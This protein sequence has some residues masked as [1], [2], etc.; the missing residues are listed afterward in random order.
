MAPEDSRRAWRA[1][2]LAGLLLI[3]S[4]ATLAV[5]TPPDDQTYTICLFRRLT[6]HACPTCG[7]TRALALLAKGDWRASIALHPLGLP[8]AAELVLLWSLSPL[9]MLRSHH[10]SAR[11][12]HVLLFANIAVF[13]MVWVLRLL[14]VFP[15]LN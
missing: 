2:L 4:W 7:M 3:G 13:M 14:H 10:L 9:A 5:W 6:H 1:W 11:S 12:V 15:S 8:L